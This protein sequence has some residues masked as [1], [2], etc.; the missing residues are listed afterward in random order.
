VTAFHGCLLL[1][2]GMSR[3][4]GGPVQGISDAQ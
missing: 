1:F 4:E 2:E 3:C